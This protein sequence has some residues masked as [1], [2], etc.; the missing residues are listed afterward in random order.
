ML[1]RL[2]SVYFKVS[3]IKQGTEE[4]IELLESMSLSATLEGDEEGLKED[5]LKFLRSEQLEDGN[6]TVMVKLTLFYHRQENEEE[7]VL[8]YFELLDYMVEVQMLFN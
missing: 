3:F 5:M 1:Q 7:S 4:T 8:E 2:E 6:Y